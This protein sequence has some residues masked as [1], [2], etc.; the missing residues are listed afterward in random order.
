MLSPI[1]YPYSRTFLVGT[2]WTRL[3]IQ[4][5]PS[6]TVAASVAEITVQTS[7]SEI[8]METGM[9]GITEE[10]DVN[11]IPS[12]QALL[13]TRTTRRTKEDIGCPRTSKRRCRSHLC[14][15]N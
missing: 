4:R 10:P 8:I 7:M 9:D 1:E 11:D 2:T 3:R 15:D 13:S 12:E 14:Y 6:P 5:Y